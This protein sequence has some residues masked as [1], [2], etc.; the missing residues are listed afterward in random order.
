MQNNSVVFEGT[1]RKVGQTL[2]N[3]W[4]KNVADAPKMHR[5]VAYVFV[6]GNAI[7]ILRTFDFELVFPE[8]NS[9]QTGVRKKA[10]E[11]LALAE[12][13]GLSTDV[14]SYVK[15]D[16]GLMMNQMHHPAGIDMPEPDL[17][18]ASTLCNTYIKWA[19]IWERHF[20]KPAFVLHTPGQ[21]FAGWNT[22]NSAGNRDRD[23]A[24]VKSQLE[25]LIDICEHIT[26]RRF[27][28]DRLAEIEENVN[29]TT[30]LWTEI[31][32]MNRLHPA[33][34][35][36]MLDGLTYMGVMNAYR[37]T[38][39]GLAYMRFLHQE[40][41][42]RVNRRESPRVSERFRLLM[43]GTPCYPN[44]RRMIELFEEHGGVF[45]YADYLTYA[46]GGLDTA[47]MIYDPSRPLES[48][49][50]VTTIASQHGLSDHFF[51]HLTL[52]TKVQ[53]FD[54][55][56][57]VYHGVKSCRTV[58]TSMADSREFVGSHY[59]VSTLYIESDLIDPRYWSDAQIKNRVDAFFEVLEQ[60]STS[61]SSGS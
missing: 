22:Q 59:G 53:E 60:R 25:D 52:G 38:P 40:L 33:P 37:G 3:Q 32:D 24:W 7:E 17:A 43:S 55:D 61:V 9:L 23:I 21:R 15:A 31:L 47:G 29:E 12:D 11:Y 44:L 46:A 5:P 30:R 45:V 18:I 26:K 35:N 39:E 4:L 8:I 42:D 6:M 50:E 34:F 56:G 58:S 14:C 36:A 49:A 1:A 19:E 20:Q 2:I 13:D 27:D 41:D 16:V 51:S 54:A 10:P 48:L 28:P 57:I